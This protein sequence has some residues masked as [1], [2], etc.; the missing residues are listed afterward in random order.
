M[1]Q[2]QEVKEYIDQVVEDL[3]APSQPTEDSGHKPQIQERL[4]T[5]QKVTVKNMNSCRFGEEESSVIV[6]DKRMGRTDS[7]AMSSIG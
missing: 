1:D 3:D 7:E 2:D 4:I 6:Y 5:N